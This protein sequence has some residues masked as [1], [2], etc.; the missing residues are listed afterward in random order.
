MKL[1]QTVSIRNPYSRPSRNN[2]QEQG[3]V[4][5]LPHQ[6]LPW[7]LMEM[8]ALLGLPTRLSF[9]H[10]L[11]LRMNRPVLITLTGH[12]LLS[13]LLLFSWPRAQM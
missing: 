12:H 4:V 7:L 2:R 13:N 6:S 5:M 3:P 10:K 11:F 1:V 9:N 8:T